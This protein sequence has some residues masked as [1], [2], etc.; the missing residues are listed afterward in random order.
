MTTTPNGRLNGRP[1]LFVVYGDASSRDDTN[2]VSRESDAAALLAPALSLVDLAD[3]Y[4]R[5]VDELAALIEAE[6]ARSARAH[7]V[8]AASLAELHGAL[9]ELAVRLRRAGGQS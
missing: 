7:A 8:L 9:D 1:D 3:T 5:Q 2:A 4:A 6:A